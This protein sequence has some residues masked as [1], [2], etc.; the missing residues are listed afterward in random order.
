MYT[1]SEKYV[2]MGRVLRGGLYHHYFLSRR[3]NLEDVCCIPVM[4][5]NIDDALIFYDSHE[6]FK[7]FYMLDPHWLSVSEV[8]RLEYTFRSVNE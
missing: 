2:V 6:A 3:S 4:T 5:D 8:C 1:N 7:A